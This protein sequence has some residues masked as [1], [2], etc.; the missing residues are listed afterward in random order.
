MI[1]SVFKKIFGS[2][3]TKKT[4]IDYPNVVEHYI[5]TS[6]A[7]GV[8]SDPNEDFDERKNLLDPEVFI[9]LEETEKK[10]NEILEDKKSSKYIICDGKEVQIEWDKVVLWNEKNNPKSLSYS[11][12]DF[13]TQKSRKPQMVILHYDV[14]QT[15]KQMFEVTKQR[16]LSVHFGVDGDGT[17][18]QLMDCK[19]IAWHA[20]GANTVS[21]GIEICNPVLPK[22]NKA[23]KKQ[24]GK[25]RDLINTDMIHGRNIGPYLDYYQEQIDAVYALIKSLCGYYNIPLVF[26]MDKDGHISLTVDQMVVNNTFK[27]VCGHYHLT[28]NKNDPGSVLLRWLSIKNG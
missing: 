5:S 6:K 22:F 12:T 23:Q 15:T 2:N 27:G 10:S 16:G 7:S 8:T 25:E 11:P 20:K 13:K 1:C 21:V 14:C 18:Y 3:K 26:P 9:R 19:D 28:T 17:I 4:D 24:W